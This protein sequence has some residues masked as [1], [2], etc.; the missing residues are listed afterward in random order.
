MG[1]QE[2]V[3]SSIILEIK[4]NEQIRACLQP[5]PRQLTGGEPIEVWKEKRKWSSTT[6]VILEAK[7]YTSSTTRDRH[8]A[9]P[10]SMCKED[11]L[12][13]T[14]STGGIMPVDKINFL[15]LRFTM[16]NGTRSKNDVG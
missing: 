10:V 9:F 8:P 13:G 16:G 1:R 11:T 6:C 5:N 7:C 4:K 15:Q 2:H 12:T 3:S 14:N